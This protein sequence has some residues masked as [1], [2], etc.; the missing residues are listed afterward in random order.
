VWGRPF[1]LR[2]GL[3]DFEALPGCGKFSNRSSRALKPTFPLSLRTRSTITALSRPAFAA[4]VWTEASSACRTMFYS[5]SSASWRVNCSKDGAIHIP[6]PL[7]WSK[8]GLIRGMRP[9]FFALIRRPNVPV[10]GN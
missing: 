6:R 7:S 8:S 5:P 1:P 4:I 2:V 3:I 10:Q 9:L